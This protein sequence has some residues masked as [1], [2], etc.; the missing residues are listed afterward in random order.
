MTVITDMVTAVV[1]ES[2]QLELQAR[3]QENKLEI[4]KSL[5]QKGCKLSSN[6]TVPPELPQTAPPTRYTYG[7]H[8]IRTP[9]PQTCTLSNHSLRHQ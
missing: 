9:Q 6:K 8:N 7:G 4:G 2:S 3:S 5:T 1:T